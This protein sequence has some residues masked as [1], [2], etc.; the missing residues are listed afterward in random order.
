MNTFITIATKK[1]GGCEIIATPD[2]PYEKQRENF[3]K[4]ADANYSEIEMWSRSQGKIRS[5]KIKASSAPVE[6]PKEKVVSTEEKVTPPS[7]S[8]PTVETPTVEESSK[9]AETPSEETKTAPEVESK[10]SEPTVETPKEKTPKQNG[11]SG[12]GSGGK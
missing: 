3:K 10:P 4:F 12:K 8:K 6:N 11:K 1:S 7:E 2:V 9:D 5:R